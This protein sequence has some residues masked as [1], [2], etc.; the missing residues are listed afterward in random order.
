MTAFSTSSISPQLNKTFICLI[1]KIN[2]PE[3]ITH[4]RH[5]SLCN[6]I[7]K[8]TTNIIVKRI[9]LFLNNVISLKQWS[10]I[11]GRRALDNAIIV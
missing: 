11:Q 9:R 3:Q 1:P 4:Y 7:Y 2:N 10:F 8:T 6:T 5:I